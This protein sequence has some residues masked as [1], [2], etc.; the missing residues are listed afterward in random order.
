ML[1]LVYNKCML[2]HYFQSK[3]NMTNIPRVYWCMHEDCLESLTCYETPE[4][5]DKHTKKH[6]K[7]HVRWAD[8]V[9]KKD[10]ADIA[11]HE[12]DFSLTDET[13]LL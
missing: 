11:N 1:T 6:S 10:N 9:D 8:L 12:Y 13:V 4:D 3:K 5:R 2:K 7:K